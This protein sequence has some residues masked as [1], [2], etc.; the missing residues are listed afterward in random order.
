ML[1]Q[2]VLTA[3]QGLRGE[4]ARL[5]TLVCDAAAS[6]EEAARAAERGERRWIWLLFG[7]GGLLDIDIS[8]RPIYG[9]GPDGRPLQ[10][11]D[12]TGRTYQPRPGA[13]PIGTE[14]GIPIYAPGD[15][16]LVGG[17]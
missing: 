12:P 9:Y 14:N 11:P 8:G 13:R 2:R 1:L 3:T 17:D 15:M 6:A 5:R 16:E 10:R 7:P 4:I